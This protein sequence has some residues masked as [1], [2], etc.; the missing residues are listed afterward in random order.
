MIQISDPQ[1]LETFEI[2]HLQCPVMAWPP[3]V[4]LPDTVVHFMACCAFLAW[5]WDDHVAK[6]KLK[7]SKNWTFSP[8]FEWCMKTRL[9]FAFNS[10]T[11]PAF[12]S[13]L[14]TTST[15]CLKGFPSSSWKRKNSLKPRLNF[16]DPYLTMSFPAV[17]LNGQ[18]WMS[19][20]IFLGRALWNLPCEK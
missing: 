3:S 2:Q 10:H 4:W 14:F 17:F 18:T 13:P 16:N 11:S 15:I 6:T 7:L 12:R 5:F 20:G 19:S 1:N 9:I 8:E